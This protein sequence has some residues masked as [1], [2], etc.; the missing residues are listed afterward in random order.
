[1]LDRKEGLHIL[2]VFGWTVA[3]A[4]VAGL[5]SLAG[6][7]HVPAEYLFLLPLVNTALVAVHQYVKDNGTI[8]AEAVQNP[9][10]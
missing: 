7:L 4:L 1:M 10:N 6:S 8:E 3:S 9:E 2:K 5:I